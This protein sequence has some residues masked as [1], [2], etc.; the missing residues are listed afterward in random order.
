[1][2][3]QAEQ[4]GPAGALAPHGRESLAIAGLFY[5]RP[6][7]TG[8]SGGRIPEGGDVLNTG[9]LI[10]AAG[11]SE[12]FGSDKRTAMLTD[13]STLLASSTR[14]ALASTLPV[15]VCLRPGDEA[16]ADQLQSMGAQTL[17]CSQAREG[18]GA[19]LACGVSHIEG[20]AG[21]LV[22]LG[23]MPFIEPA[24]YCKVAQALLPG[25]ICQ[26]IYAGTKG[27]P[28]G[29]AASYFSQ[30]ASLAGD[31]GARFLVQK[32]PEAV[33]RLPVDDPGIVR[34]VDNLADLP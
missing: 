20:W 10:L 22:A 4:T 34:D 30:L 31:R 23:D 27:H 19:T 7:V 9:I 26:P 21:V 17:L 28:V 3:G 13:G 15:L 5:A 29:F 1:V 33:I 18:M 2:E 12:R 32:N 24:T 14:R 25:A 8:C 11:S 16:L 6:E